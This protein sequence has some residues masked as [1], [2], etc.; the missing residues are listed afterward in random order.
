MI[1]KCVL[2]TLAALAGIFILQGLVCAQTT[3]D[4][5]A[6]GKAANKPSDAKSPGYNIV[7]PSDA[8]TQET[9][10]AWELTWHLRTATH[11]WYEPVSESTYDGKKPAI[12]VG[13]TKYALAQGCQPRFLPTDAFEIKVVGKNI[14]LCGTRPRGTVYAV[15]EY[16]ESSCRVMWFTL[17]GEME[18][19]RLKSIP[20]P[21]ESKTYKPAFESR[22]FMAASTRFRSITDV[23]ATDR[24]FAMNRI[25]GPSTAMHYG[26]KV[27]SDSYGGVF[28]PYKTWI[29][30]TMT[31]FVSPEA[32]QQTHPE[33]LAMREDGT[34]TTESLCPTNQGMRELFLTNLKKNLDETGRKGM[35]S[36]SPPDLEVTCQ[37]PE[38]KAMAEKYHSI[39]AG[40][41]DFVN[42][43]AKN[44]VRE[45]PDAKLE[46]LAYG[47]FKVPPTGMTCEP[48]VYVRF[49]AAQRS[50]WDKLDSAG[51]KNHMDYLAGWS[52]MAPNHIRIWDYPLH[53]GDVYPIF[54]ISR[55]K[56]GETGVADWVKSAYS[57]SAVAKA[58]LCIT[59]VEDSGAKQFFN[60]DPF[61]LLRQPTLIVSYRAAG[62]LTLA[63]LNPTASAWVSSDVPDAVPTLVCQSDVVAAQIVGNP[64]SRGL[65]SFAYLRFDLSTLP[66]GAEI[67]DAAFELSKSGETDVKADETFAVYAVPKG[68]DW[69]AAKLTW[70][71]QPP[72]NPQPLFTLPAYK[73]KQGF[74]SY[75]GL[76]PQP[77]LFTLLDNLLKYQ[78]MGVQGMFLETDSSIIEQQNN[79]DVVYWALAKGM[80]DTSRNPE[81]LVRDYCLAYYKKAG[82]DVFAYFKQIDQAYTAD[83]VKIGFFFGKMSKQTFF[84]YK[85]AKDLQKLFDDGASKVAGDPVLE[86]RVMRAR[87][88]LDIA[89]LFYLNRFA[90]EYK[91]SY[92]NLKD[93]AFD[94]RTIEDRYS[95][96]RIKMIEHLYPNV[97]KDT[98][99]E[100]ITKLF[101]TA[102][103]MPES[104]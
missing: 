11:E 46:L 7:Y 15:A 16:L 32:N 3:T 31:S 2:T 104:W 90:A 49:A 59:M 10:A 25:N 73:A 82:Q 75:D 27:P 72:I 24:W 76:F 70:S 33:Y 28:D 22:D 20:L 78:Q 56:M 100:N 77:N 65:K 38:C 55:T 39:S 50:H 5:L 79:A 63:E 29:A 40:Y 85:L 8:T 21:K 61:P 68:S 13:W 102:S 96:S 92:E 57:D 84:T 9:T 47:P 35:Y 37:C 19:P 91:L 71:S 17:V 48:N 42:Y 93:F 83:P 89:T 41:V 1:N 95:S 97:S 88:P 62:R 67:V 81:Y 103:T 26:E 94:R 23:K 69:D 43:I 34:R 74:Q 60:I 52:K 12:Y 86:E 101:A 64:Q 6:Y 66:K 18:I 4:P 54:S 53:Y 30:H 80:W 58:G 51:N 36:I 44:V 99:K 98:E 45:N 14:V 87:M